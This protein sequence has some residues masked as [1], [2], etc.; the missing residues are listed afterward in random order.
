MAP[1]ASN[2]TA[3]SKPKKEK[4]FHPSSRKAGQLART[5]IRKG[6]LGNLTTQR[7]HKTNNIVDHFSFWFQAIPGEGVLT[8][9]GLHQIVQDVWLTRWDEALEAERTARRKGRSKSVK[10]LKLEE[11]R[12]QES[13]L[14]RTGMEV[15]DLTHLPTVEL[16]RRWDLKEAAYLQ[17]LRYIR[18]NRNDP[19]TAV[20]S[21]PGK[22]VSI[23]ESN[24]T[25]NSQL[26]IELKTQAQ[27]S[28]GEVAMIT[29]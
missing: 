10:E 13:E 3:K 11:T 12:L 5:A 26:D 7:H 17:L 24:P 8:L 14:Y 29:L 22:H 20:V 1:V 18:I 4:I 6:R 25:Q 16:F 9:D 27:L 19:K 2:K 28:I 21:K 15:P 23:L